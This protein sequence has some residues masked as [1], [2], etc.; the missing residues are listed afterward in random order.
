MESSEVFLSSL[1]GHPEVQAG[2]GVA[3]LLGCAC[4]PRLLPGAAAEGLSPLSSLAA[5]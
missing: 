2:E 4:A 3:P 5:L 1:D